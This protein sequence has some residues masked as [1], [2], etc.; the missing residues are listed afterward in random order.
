MILKQAG[1]LHPPPKYI[2]N[3]N[4]KGIPIAIDKNKSLFSNSKIPIIPIKS[5]NQIYDRNFIIDGRYISMSCDMNMQLTA[6]VN[7]V[8]TKTIETKVQV[9]I[10][11][12]I[13]EK[14]VHSPEPG[15]T[16]SLISQTF[17]LRTI[18]TNSTF[19][20]VTSEFQIKAVDLSDK[21]NLYYELEIPTNLNIKNVSIN[22]SQLT[23][24]PYANT[25]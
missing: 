8:L 19:S 15:S 12:Y 22:T 17:T 23:I 25:N 5:I 1:N 3:Y 11:F 9:I 2:I 6:S 13:I 14:F 18:T 7:F 16:P 4:K 24:L 21:Y 10:K 20:L